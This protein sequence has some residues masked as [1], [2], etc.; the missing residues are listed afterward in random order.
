MILPR[1]TMTDS[2]EKVLSKKYSGDLLKKVK[3]W[4]FVKFLIVFYTFIS[5]SGS[6]G[7]PHSVG[8]FS[9]RRTTSLEIFVP[10]F[11]KSVLHPPLF[12]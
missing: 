6:L 5:L 1:H 11:D 4:F 2:E 9:L 10:L 7:K 3:L 8:K 12:F